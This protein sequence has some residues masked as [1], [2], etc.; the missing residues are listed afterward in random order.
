MSFCPILIC[1]T[2][3]CDIQHGGSRHLEFLTKSHISEKLCYQV[4]IVQENQIG[5]SQRYQMLNTPCLKILDGGGCHFVDKRTSSYLSNVYLVISDKFGLR[6][7]DVILD[8]AGCVLL[9]QR[10]FNTTVAD[11]LNFHLKRHN[12]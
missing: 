10:K 3:F 2:T 12:T 8:H 5:H 7:N 6:M 9:R 4:E 1:I 11:V